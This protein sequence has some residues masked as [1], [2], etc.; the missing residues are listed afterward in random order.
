M[1]K[2]KRAYVFNDTPA[3]FKDMNAYKIVTLAPGWLQ[4]QINEGWLKT[5]AIYNTFIN[6]VTNEVPATLLKKH[7]DATIYCDPDSASMLPEELIKK[8]S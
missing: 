1:Y 3:D 4:Q 8:Y 5:E 6:D 7:A 2:Q